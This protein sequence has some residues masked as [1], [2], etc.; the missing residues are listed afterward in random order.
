VMVNQ[1]SD[2]QNNLFAQ[3]IVNDAP[4]FEEE[5]IT[6]Y[7]SNSFLSADNLSS[8]QLDSDSYLL[9]W[10]DVLN[11]EI[12]GRIVNNGYVSDLISLTTHP[13]HHPTIIQ[14]EDHYFMSYIKIGVWGEY[15][16]AFIMFDNSLVPITDPEGFV[17]SNSNNSN[18]SM[19]ISN[20]CTN[21]NRDV[22]VT[23]S[24]QDLVGSSGLNIFIQ[25]INDLGLPE[26]V[27][28]GILLTDNDYTD[29]IVQHVSSNPNSGAVVFWSTNSFGS[30]SLFVTSL[31]EDGDFITEWG[32]EPVALDTSGNFRRAWFQEGTDGI[33]VTWTQENEL[34]WKI[35][36]RFIRYNGELVPATNEIEVF[37]SNSS[38]RSSLGSVLLQ[39]GNSLNAD[40]CGQIFN[41]TKY[42][43][44]CRKINILNGEMSE[45]QIISNSSNGDYNDL[46]VELG[47]NQELMISWVESDSPMWDNHELKYQEFTEF[48]GPSVFRFGGVTVS[49]NF[50]DFDHIGILPNSSED[51]SALIYWLDGRHSIN[52][53]YSS[54]YV[55]SR[56]V[57]DNSCSD[58]VGDINRDNILDVL[59]LIIILNM[60]I[61]EESFEY[62][63]FI[64]SDANGDDIVDILDIVLL[65]S[66]IME[67]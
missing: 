23:Y 19:P 53:E 43:L 8:I 20:S 3:K 31:D 41:G 39:Q 45:I 36:A 7:Q 38:F 15:Q 11:T 12:A 48:P 62:C 24:V 47:S 64:I 35:L 52:L 42:D 57:L 25:K 58:V 18:I 28:G 6:L 60:I 17:I 1:P 54:V 44:Q 9:Y 27:E 67:E 65:V 5:G 46:D 32:N 56:T 30:K 61:N 51:N 29:E 33:L 2:S 59:D 55:Q 34:E 13:S 22:F 21:N 14:V 26:W 16:A 49:N 50:F 10:E 66:Y 4:F 40:I 63:P 37:N